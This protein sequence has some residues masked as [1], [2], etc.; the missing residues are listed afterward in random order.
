[1]VVPTDGT[2]RSWF[3]PEE[4]LSLADGLVGTATVSAAEDVWE[5]P[6]ASI[7]QRGEVN[8]VVRQRDGRATVIEVEI[9]TASGASALV[10][11]PL[12]PGDRVAAEFPIADAS[13]S[14]Q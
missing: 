8:E 4:D 11:G 3:E 9:A 1:V 12:G 5:L 13:E 2:S 6:A 7:R 14:P 10:R